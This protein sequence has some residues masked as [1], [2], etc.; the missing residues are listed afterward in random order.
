MKIQSMTSPRTG[1]AVANQFIIVEHGNGANGNFTTRRTF[2]SYASVIATITWWSDGRIDTVLDKDAWNYSK[3]TSK[4][5]CEFLGETTKET[6]E[7]IDNG[8]YTLTNL[9]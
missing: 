9:N 6:Q 2:Q 8:T 5:R 3:T 1:K 7:K 4:Y